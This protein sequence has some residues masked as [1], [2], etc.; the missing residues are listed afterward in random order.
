MKTLI[1]FTLIVVMGLAV[2][3]AGPG[4]FINNVGAGGVFLFSGINSD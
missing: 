3:G 4:S 1:I 2:L